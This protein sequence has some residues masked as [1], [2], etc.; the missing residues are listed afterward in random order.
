MSCGMIT[1][2]TCA[3]V[4]R[5]VIEVFESI[6]EVVGGMV[7]VGPPA[8]CQKTGSQLYTYSTRLGLACLRKQSGNLY[9]TTLHS[10]RNSSALLTFGYLVSA[11]AIMGFYLRPPSRIFLL[12]HMSKGWLPSNQDTGL[13]VDVSPTGPSATGGPQMFQSAG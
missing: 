8:C 2:L 4:D 9:S 3:V 7:K 13:Q 10:R 5:F 6:Q 12:L 1:S 11:F